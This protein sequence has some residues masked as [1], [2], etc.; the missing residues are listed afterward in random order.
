MDFQKKY[1][2]YKGKYLALKNKADLISELRLTNNF[3]QTRKQLGGVES[4]Y[5]LTGKR[6]YCYSDE[7]GGN[8]FKLQKEIGDTDSKHIFAQLDSDFVFNDGLIVEFKKP[9]VA[10]TFLGDLLDNSKYSIRLLQ[11]FIRLKQINPN[12]VILIGGNRDFNKIRMGIE[13]YF[14]DPTKAGVDQLPWNGTNNF[15]ELKTRLQNPMYNFQFR[16]KRVPEYLKDV[17]LWDGAIGLLE[18]EYNKSFH[19]RLDTMFKKTKGVNAFG[20][21]G[22]TFIVDELNDMFALPDASKLRKGDEISAR[23]ICM[24][25]MIMAFDWG[26]EGLPHYLESFNGLYI[27]YLEQCHVISI[28]AIGGKFGILSHSGYPKKLTFP[29]GYDSENALMK[30]SKGSLTNVV[31]NIEREKYE[32]ILQVKDK[33]NYMYSYDADYMINKFVHLTAA[34]IFDNDEGAKA[35]N[36]PVVWGQLTQTNQRP[37]IKVQIKGGKGFRSWIDKDVY[38][39]DK[40][41]V[42]D[43]DGSMI[44]YNIF[45]HAP[46]FF[47]PTLFRKSA[48][49]TLHVNLDISKIEAN[50]ANSNSANNYS[51]AFLYIDGSGVDKVIGR[52]KLPEPIKVFPHERN[53]LSEIIKKINGLPKPTGTSA[54]ADADAALA[55]TSAELNAEKAR[56]NSD[57]NKE[58]AIMD[59]ATLAFITANP[60]HYYSVDIT[61]DAIDISL[62]SNIPETPIKVQSFKPIDFTKYLYHE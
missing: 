3:N 25:Q 38:H 42:N 55:A 4:F 54:T 2:K 61:N 24:I 18:A 46:Q 59:D 43:E 21:C 41:Y 12:S 33:K 50:N 5:D 53:A 17:K 51:F 52:I 15:D 45:G 32:L 49:S 9:D 23:I 6:L 20:D 36:S 40:I 37:E 28:F 22:Y 27:K 10:L 60:I 48:G 47:N 8:P 14:H 16:D 7:E 34:T 13:L 19:A 35:S 57:I 62:N 30:F 29:F 39:A 31:A 44:S 56:I 58:I 1:L 26:R 11:S